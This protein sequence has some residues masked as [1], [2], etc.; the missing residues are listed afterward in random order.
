MSLD[1]ITLQ[2][3]WSRLVSIVDEAATGLVRTAY[4]SMVRDFHDYC[5]AVF[6]RDGNMLAHSTKTTAGFIGIVPEV[7]RHFIAHFPTEEME[8]GDVFITNDPWLAAG[9]LLDIAAASPIFVNGNIV[10]FGLCI[11][12]HYDMGGRLATTESKSMYEEGLKL[13]ILKLYS[14]GKL[15]TKIIDIIRA[16]VRVPERIIGD[17]RAQIASNNVCT[18]GIRKL[19]QDTQLEDLREVGR[20]IV[21]LT[22]NSLRRKIAELPDGTYRNSAVL[23]LIGSLKEPIRI[24][25]A[26]TVEGDHMVIDYEGSSGEVEAALN[27]TLNMTRS[28]SVYPI[29]LALDPHIPNNEG[30]LR[31]ITIRAPEGGL[32]NCKPPAATWGRTIIAHNFPEI[33]FGALIKATPDRVIAACGSTPLAAIYLSGK[34]KTGEAFLGFVAHLGGFGARMGSDG[35]SCLGF[36]YNVANIPIEVTER[37]ASVLYLRKE[38]MA[39]SGGAGRYRGGLG[40]RVE[41]MVPEGHLGPDGH[42][43]AAIRGSGRAPGS[44]FPITGR[45]GGGPGD[46]D[47]LLINGKAIPHGMQHALQPNDVVTLGMPGGGGIGDPRQRPPEDVLADVQQGFVT[48]AAAEAAYGV[49]I[50]ERADAIDQAA[51]SLLRASGSTLTH[52]H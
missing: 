2:I 11:V 29:K 42:V 47:A 33:I 24:E 37:D 28:Y 16:N 48:H 26:L 5:C 32:L 7:V 45:N 10:G 44:T 13:P 34:R 50:D 52:K 9:H 38:L 51:T 21:S 30:F 40:Q 6:D 14:A 20:Q 41:F 25:V 36:P 27:V 8:E 35:P 39:D 4:S 3:V 22:E 1:P 17:L 19:M 46:G 23:P 43:T 18:A 49:K 31:P 15:D 12:H